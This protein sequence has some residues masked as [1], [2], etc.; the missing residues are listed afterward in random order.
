MG[1]RIPGEELLCIATSVSC[2]EDDDFEDHGND[3]DMTSNVLR[4][5]GG[6]YCGTSPNS[7][8]QDGAYVCSLSMFLL[9]SI[10]LIFFSRCIM[11][12]YNY[13]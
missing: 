10:L 8:E 7:M 5:A 9:R 3:G 1:E 13:L 2:C 4:F 6:D 11:F 12:M